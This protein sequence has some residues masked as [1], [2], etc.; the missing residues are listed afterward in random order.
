MKPEDTTAAKPP[1][2]LTVHERILKEADEELERLIK[3]YPEINSVG[4]VIDWN[5]PNSQQMPSGVFVCRFTGALSYMYS[6]MEATAR[7]SNGILR[8]IVNTIKIKTKQENQ[9]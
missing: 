7:F 6:L 2:Q 1:E 9:K 5:L 8:E 3:T 4:F